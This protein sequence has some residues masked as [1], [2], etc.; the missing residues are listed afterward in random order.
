[1][2]I[3][4]QPKGNL[5]E[6]NAFLQKQ[7]EENKRYDAAVKDGRLL[8]GTAG[9]VSEPA[10]ATKAGEIGIPSPIRERATVGGPFTDRTKKY[11][12]LQA[13]YPGYVQAGDVAHGMQAGTDQPVTYIVDPN[14]IIY[15]P[16]FGYIAP[17][18]QFGR[19]GAKGQTWWSKGGWG[20]LAPLGYAAGVALG[21]G[22]AATAAPATTANALEM[23]AMPGVLG[24]AGS[25]A[26][27]SIPGTAAFNATMGGLVPSVASAGSGLIGAVPTTI[28]SSG[29]GG[30][31]NQALGWIGN[32]PLQALSTAN[33]L[34]GGQPQ[35][36]QTMEATD[37][38][39]QYAPNTSVADIGGAVVR[40]V[41]SGAQLTD[42]AG[43][44]VWG[45][46][47]LLTGAFR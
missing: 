41:P 31:I 32:H 2:A 25:G 9:R 13:K 18:N 14:T 21:G 19:A 20:I 26:A 43:N 3:W 44:P 29:G 17:A 4:G 35:Q 46:Q 37:W 1:M 45:D 27:A 33:L 22:L 40:V 12:L 34:M 36:P 8:Y 23:G 10:P 30:L 15:D 5:D 39:Q 47:G 24:S 11:D 7:L 38:A 42:R 28:S 16:E 6:V